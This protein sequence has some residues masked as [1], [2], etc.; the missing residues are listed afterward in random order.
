MNISKFLLID[1]ALAIAVIPLLFLIQG[2]TRKSPLLKR[3][4]KEDLLKKT[5]VKLPEKEKL[6]ELRN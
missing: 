6:I 3:T 2:G 4:N 1:A 5:S